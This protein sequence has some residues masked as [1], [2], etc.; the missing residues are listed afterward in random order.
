[1]NLLG[2]DYGDKKIGLAIASG[3]LAEPLSVLR[4]KTEEE[5]VKKVTQVVQVEHVDKIIIGLSEGRT[6]EKTK[7]FGQKLQ[8]HTILPIEYYDETLSTHEAQSLSR[9][10]GMKRS[11]RAALEDAFAACVILQNYLDL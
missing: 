4:V 5:A 9:E 8:S 3:K 2:I 7:T 6:A 11:K 1:M 10:S